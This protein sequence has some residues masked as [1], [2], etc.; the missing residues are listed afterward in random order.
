MGLARDAYRDLESVV[1]TENISEDDAVLLS[2]SFS[3][4]GLYPET[5]KFTP[6]LPAAVLLPEY[7][8]EIQTIVKTCNRHKIGFK[9]HSTGWGPWG[10]AGR[11]NIVLLDLRRMNRIIDIDEKNMFAVIEPCVVAGQLQAEAMKKGLDCHITG[12]GAGH[13]PL[14]SATSFQGMGNKGLT[15]STNERNVL[16]VEWVLPSGDILSLGSPS[17]GAGWFSGDGP[18]PSLRGIMRGYIGASGGLGVFTKIGFKLYPWTGEK[19]PRMMGTNPQYFMSIP[20]NTKFYYPYWANW[21]DMID[22]SYKIID[23]EVAH[24]LTRIPPDAIGYYFTRTNTEFYELHKK[25]ALP[26]LRKHRMGWNSI[27]AAHSSKEFQYKKKVFEKIVEITKGRFVELTPEQ[28]A[29]LYTAAIKVCYLP[30]VARPTGDF[31]TCFGLDDSLSLMKKVTEVGE[32]HRGPFVK[33]GKFVNDGPEGFW[34][35][36]YEQG[37]YLHWENAYHFDPRDPESRKASLECIMKSAD[38]IEEGGLGVAMLPNLMGPFADR[39]GP[40]LGNAHIWMRKIKNAFDPDNSAD[41]SFYIS[42]EPPR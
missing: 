14:A 35:W 15:T 12:A 4:F 27:I 34:G 38:M 18:G 28:E 22:A 21:D 7:V 20:D 26:I 19:K 13:S 30:R 24:S 1:G 16:G 36:P 37:K 32:A 10:L 41:H 42:P 8:E 23:A 33:A 5:G 11:E 17:I 6:L 40:A 39:F 29:L 3:P 31:C 2:Y 25:D 9:A